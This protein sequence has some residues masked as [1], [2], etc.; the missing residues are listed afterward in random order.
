[1]TEE[2]KKKISDA[3]RGKRP[4]NL[5][6]LHNHITGKVRLDM[7]GNKNKFWKGDNVGYRALHTWV[8][9][10]L[11]KATMCENDPTHISTRYHWANISQEYKRDLSDWRQLCPSC[12]SLERSF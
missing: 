12:N 2:H 7:L 8:Q 4:K 6:W 5:S 9:T 3:N 1:M 10:K 11:G